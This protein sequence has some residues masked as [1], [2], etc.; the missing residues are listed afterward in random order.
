[1]TERLAWCTVL[2]RLETKKLNDAKKA[3]VI[4][5]QRFLEARPGTVTSDIAALSMEVLKSSI[6]SL[7]SILRRP[8]GAAIPMMSSES[9]QIKREPSP[10]KRAI[11]PKRRDIMLSE[12]T[13]FNR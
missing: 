6:S 1:M 11:W 10:R 4:S 3:E 2:A 5:E 9:M 12:I 13:L 8:K 7:K